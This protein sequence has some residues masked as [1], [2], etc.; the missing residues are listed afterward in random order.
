M[1][2]SRTVDHRHHN[3]NLTSR[4]MCQHHFVQHILPNETAS[5]LAPGLAGPVDLPAAQRH[6]AASTSDLA[7]RNAAVAASSASGS[8]AQRLELSAAQRQTLQ[9]LR[10]E[11]RG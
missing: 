10:A 2:F 3:Q 11:A 4:S 6:F 1:A 7:R 8:E 9:L 5:R